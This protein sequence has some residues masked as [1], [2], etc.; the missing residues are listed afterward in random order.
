M[1]PSDTLVGGS[2]FDT[3]AHAIAVLAR[4]DPKLLPAGMPAR[5]GK[6]EVISHLATG[7]MADIFLARA[8]GLKGFEKL[9]II[10]RVRQALA[11]DKSIIELFLDEARLAASLQHPHIVQVY[12]I[13]IVDGN[14]FLAMEFVHG[15]DASSVLR[16]MK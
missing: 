12:E 8:R 13:G 16:K 5:F 6:Y 3:G 4:R 14:Y 2:P 11:D 10:K 9:V 7:G 1:E 15:E